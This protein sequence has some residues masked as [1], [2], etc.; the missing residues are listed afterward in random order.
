MAAYT[1]NSKVRGQ[2]DDD[3][4]IKVVSRRSLRSG[5]AKDVKA[6]HTVVLG[7]TKSDEY[8]GGTFQW[9]TKKSRRQKRRER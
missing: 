9:A 6:K 5:R 3:G 2:K 4:W 8:K 1:T 7:D